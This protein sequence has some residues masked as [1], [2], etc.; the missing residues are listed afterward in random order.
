VLLNTKQVAERYNF[1]ESHVRLLLRKGLIK[2]Q[3][4]GRDYAIN[5]SDLKKVK[6][7]RMRV[8]DKNEN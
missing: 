2:G 8:T 1:S 5:E 4:I 6:R 7:K 3:K